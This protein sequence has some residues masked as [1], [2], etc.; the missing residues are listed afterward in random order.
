MPIFNLRSRIVN[1]SG[2][3]LCAASL[4]FAYLY[5][6]KTLQLNPCPL[7]LI[8]RA[9]I[10]VMGLVFFVAAIHNPARSGQKK[11]AAVNL[12][13]ALA[14]IGVGARHVWLQYYPNPSAG[15]AAGL[16]YMLEKFPLGE[17]MKR[18]FA[19]TSDCSEVQ[20]RFLGLSIPE[21]TL[22]LFLAFTAVTLFQLLRKT[23]Y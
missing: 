17:V 23:D 9:I 2:F 12:I 19:G 18:V 11:Y 14:G 13:W 7:C 6:E 20:W 16:D 1:L 15:C 10:A 4:V 5:L 3:L 22:I 8:D 21:Q